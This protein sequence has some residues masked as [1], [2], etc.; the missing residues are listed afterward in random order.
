LNKIKSTLDFWPMAIQPVKLW[1]KD[2]WWGN[3]RWREA[4]KRM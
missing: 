2:L 4:S 3:E 1:K